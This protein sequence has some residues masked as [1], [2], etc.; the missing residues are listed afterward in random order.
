[1]KRRRL[2]CVMGCVD[3][4][5]ERRLVTRGCVVEPASSVERV[6]RLGDLISLLYGANC[7]KDSLLFVVRFFKGAKLGLVLQLLVAI[8]E[9]CRVMRTLCGAG[10][11]S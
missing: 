5:C 3:F 10:N 8:K 1:M 9:R 6:V 7:C 11:G 2:I 4:G